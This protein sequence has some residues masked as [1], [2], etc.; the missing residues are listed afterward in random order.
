MKRYTYKARD[1]KT[2]KMVKGA[3]QA[4]T[5]RL[6]GKILI[7]QGLTPEQIEEVN[8]SGFFAKLKNKVSG[9]DKIVFTRQF[10]TLIGAGLPLS[11]SLRL[12]NE[13]TTSRPMQRVIDELLADVEAGKT[14]TQACEKFPALFDHVYIALL[15]AGETSGTLDLSLKRLADQQEKDMAMMS[16]IRGALTYPAIILVVIIAVIAFM[17][18]MV[19]PQV[20]GLYNDLGKELPGATKVLVAMA[21]FVMGQWYLIVVALIVFV[22]VTL[23]FRKTNPGRRFFA[24]LKLNVP[25]FKKMFWRLYN[26]RF[27]RTAEN[28]LSTGVSIQDT[29]VIAAEAMNNVILEEQIKMAAEKVKAGKPLSES[30]KGRSYILPLVPQMVSIGEQSGKIDEM[31]GKAA[32]VYEDELDEQVAT[33]STMIEPILMVVMA[34]LIGFVV[35][36]VLMP[37]YSIVSSV[38]G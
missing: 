26:S 23:Q 12:V 9:K 5:E 14:L 36:A 37:I 17:L 24:L 20:E 16:A 38:S 30:L 10:A 2:G 3:V 33:I 27:A 8:E 13:Q 1:P 6:A 29:L 28:L 4:Q 25:I 7:E 15:R 22:V 21:N 19:V 31:L 18:L 32:K 34:L 35:L 11:N